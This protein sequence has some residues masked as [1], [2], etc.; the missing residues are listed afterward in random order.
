MYNHFGNRAAQDADQFAG[1]GE[2]FGRQVRPPLYSRIGPRT[3]RHAPTSSCKRGV[4]NQAST[5]TQLKA[6]ALSFSRAK[7][8]TLRALN[9][10]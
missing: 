9:N 10:G 4:T 6:I 1:F 8:S 3:R 7:G 2:V 5:S